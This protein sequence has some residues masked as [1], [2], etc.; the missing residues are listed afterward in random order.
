MDIYIVFLENGIFGFFFLLKKKNDNL[1]FLIFFF[2]RIQIT[3][4]SFISRK[5][6]QCISRYKG[7]YI[8]GDELNPKL[9]LIT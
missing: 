4:P 3:R 8:I 2:L 9:Q 1:K 5:K 7:N 6:L